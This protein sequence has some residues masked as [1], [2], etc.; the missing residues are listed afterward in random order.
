M[1]VLRG[2]LS[3][4]RE[5]YLDIKKKIEKRLFK[6]PK[7]SVKE[8]VIAGKK[9][10]Y[11]QYRMDKDIIQRYIGK[12]KPESIIQQRRERSALKKELKKV[13]EALRI[14]KRTEGRKHG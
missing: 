8:R 12:V 5:Y 9:Y 3:E 4:S 10:Y 14:I 1:E 6:L 2:I 11:L 13:I 7:G